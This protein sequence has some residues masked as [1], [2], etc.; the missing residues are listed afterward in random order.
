MSKQ[1]SFYMVD[2]VWG[3]RLELKHFTG[4]ETAEFYILDDDSPT[5]W[6]LRHRTR[7]PKR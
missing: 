6:A 5:C 7:I 4:R 1:I 2:E 3:D